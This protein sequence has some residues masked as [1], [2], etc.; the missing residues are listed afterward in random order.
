MPPGLSWAVPM[1]LTLISQAYP[2]PGPTSHL[3]HGL[4]PQA[5]SLRTAPLGRPRLC[6][7][8]SKGD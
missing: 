4:S 1:A 8:W 7:G 2:S 5:L 6:S 3:P